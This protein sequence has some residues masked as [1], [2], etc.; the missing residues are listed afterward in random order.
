MWQVDFLWDETEGRQQAALALA[1]DEVAVWETFMCGDL[2]PCES[3]EDPLVFLC[4]IVRFCMQNWCRSS[5]F[6]EF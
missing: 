5:F 4:G 2:T 6:W 1:G 3:Q